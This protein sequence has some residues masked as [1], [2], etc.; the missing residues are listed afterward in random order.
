MADAGAD[1]GQAGQ[2]RVEGRTPQQEALVS[3]EPVSLAKRGFV[4]RAEQTVELR[5]AG[6]VD[7]NVEVRMQLV[8]MPRTG[9]TDL[10][11]QVLAADQRIVTVVLPFADEAMTE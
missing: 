7:R 11:R 1:H 5:H 2:L 10:V 3:G 8:G 6:D 9:H 4:E